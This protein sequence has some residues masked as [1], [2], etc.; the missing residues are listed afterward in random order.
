MVVASVALFTKMLTI[1]D[2]PY[3]FTYGDTVVA[4]YRWLMSGVQDSV[5]PG[6]PEI[7]VKNTPSILKFFENSINLKKNFLLFNNRYQYN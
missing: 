4:S 2:V 1:E 6:A 7:E 5:V 3:A